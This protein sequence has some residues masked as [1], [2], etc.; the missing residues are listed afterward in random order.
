[1]IDKTL[2]QRLEWM[3]FSPIMCGGI[4]VPVAW[5]MKK[6]SRRKNMQYSIAVTAITHIVY[7]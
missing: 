3:P 5:F 1:M 6:Y 2:K 7:N 4:N